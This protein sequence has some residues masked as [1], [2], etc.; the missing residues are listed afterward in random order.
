[1]NTHASHRQI[2][3]RPTRVVVVGGYGAVGRSLVSVLADWYPGR[4]VVVGRDP[5]RAAPLPEGV[6]ALRADITRGEGL[7]GVLDGATVVVMCVEKANEQVARACFARGIHYVDISATDT[8]LTSIERLQ[9]LATTNQAAGVLSVGVAP[10]LTNVAVRRCLDRMPDAQAIDITVLLG[11]G[12]HHGP[13]AVRW[14]I[15][16][17]AGPTSGTGGPRRVS[18][19]LPGFG[20]RTAF[21]F[22]FSDQHTMRRISGV[23]VTTRLCFD[24]APATWAVFAL[25]AIRLFTVART[26]HASGP[27]AR[28]LGLVHMGDD[29][30]VVMASAVDGDGTTVRCAI[31]GRRQSRATGVV[32]AHAVRALVDGTVDP[33]VRHLDQIIDPAELLDR[34]GEHGLE[35]T[36]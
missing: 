7:E 33:G 4:V 34:L 25:R 8:V 27:L 28:A 10:G 19:E 11:L 26:M 31:S 14:T 21:A 5:A 2:G 12:E 17:L 15:D 6:T 3:D 30:F 29:R 1:V 22:P 20:R 32:A 23:P 18:V 36:T 35:V 13:D 16:R 24:S 9:G